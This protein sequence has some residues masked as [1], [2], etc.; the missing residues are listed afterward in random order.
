MPRALGLFSL[1]GPMEELE[2][3]AQSLADDMLG[4]TPLGL[5]MTKE[6]LTHALDASSLEAVMAME[7]RQQVLC[8]QGDNFREGMQAFLEKRLPRYGRR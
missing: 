1:L 7:D 2:R 8:T 6:G 5:R 4:V 3:E